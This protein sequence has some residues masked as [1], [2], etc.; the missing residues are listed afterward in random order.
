MDPMAKVQARSQRLGR[1]RFSVLASGSLLLGI[2]AACSSST[3]PESRDEG[4][5]LQTRQLEY[6]LAGDGR[7]WAT[8]IDYEY[9]NSS[10]ETVYLVN[11]NGSFALV[12]ERLDGDEWKIAWAPVLLA[13]LSA[14][15][16][17]RPGE[18][19]QD[20]L[21]VWGS[22]P[23]TNTA[24]QFALQDPDGV[25]RIVW[26]DALSSFQDRLPFGER[27]PL[28]RRVSNRFILKK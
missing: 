2:L 21:R 14:P 7:G 10:D 8:E 13:C 6:V 23:G 22:P 9:T 3:A 15:I 12:L 19:F 26:V 27:I 5:L 18:V 16:T 28:S 20:T 17:I 24:P 11:C 1:Q 25:Y 4:P